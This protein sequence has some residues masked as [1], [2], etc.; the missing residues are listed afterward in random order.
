MERGGNRD[1]LGSD[2]TLDDNFAI[3]LLK[4]ARKFSIGWLAVENLLFVAAVRIGEE[5]AH[6]MLNKECPSFFQGLE[7]QGFANEC[8][9][10][11]FVSVEESSPATVV[12]DRA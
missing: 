4:C 7:S 11:C 1:L 2:R 6:F 12:I 5:R 8:K 10:Q 3:L 9:C